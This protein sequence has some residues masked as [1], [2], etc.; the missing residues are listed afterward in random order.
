MPPEMNA[1]GEEF[2]RMLSAIAVNGLASAVRRGVRTLTQPARG[3]AG[4]KANPLRKFIAAGPSDPEVAAWMSAHA[5]ARKENFFRW[6]RRFPPTP[7][8]R[9]LKYADWLRRGHYVRRQG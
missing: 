5:Q 1:K 6:C 3:R 9:L 8:R 7:L 4:L 2:M